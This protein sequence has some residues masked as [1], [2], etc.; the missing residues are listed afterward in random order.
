MG[1][2]RGGCR[3]LVGKPEGK[4][5]LARPRSRWED[6]KMDFQVGWGGVEWIDPAQDMDRRRTVVNAIMNLQVPHNVRNIL[7]S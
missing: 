3:V 4:S 5:Q 6:I 1:D 7:T 2:R